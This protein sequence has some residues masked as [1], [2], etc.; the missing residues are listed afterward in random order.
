MYLSIFWFRNKKRYFI[1]LILTVFGTKEIIC[2]NN[3]ANIVRSTQS[4]RGVNI[5]RST[6]SYRVINI[7]R[8]THCIGDYTVGRSYFVII[9]LWVDLEFTKISG[10]HLVICERLIRKGECFFISKG[11]IHFNQSKQVP[12]FDKPGTMLKQIPFVTE[13][14]CNQNLL[15]YL[16]FRKLCLKLTLYCA[17]LFKLSTYTCKPTSS[18]FVLPSS[19]TCVIVYET[20]LCNHLF[21]AI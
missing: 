19:F 5:V 16:I 2:W 7:V 9:L 10:V 13:I 11:L 18:L 4:Y 12:F 1:S 3:I 17:G 20:K 8:G 6:Q 14:K 21:Q 15:Q